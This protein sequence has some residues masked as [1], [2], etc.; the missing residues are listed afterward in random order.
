M[1]WDICA[2]FHSVKHSMALIFQRL[3]KIEIHPLTGRCLG[4]H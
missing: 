1:D 4:F 3:M 2:W